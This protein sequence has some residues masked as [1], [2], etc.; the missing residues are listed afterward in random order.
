MTNSKMMTLTSHSGERLTT[1]YRC[2]TTKT[3]KR[4]TLVSPM[5]KYVWSNNPKLTKERRSTLTNKLITKRR[6]RSKKLMK[7]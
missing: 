7:K 3:K 6:N 5:G 1:S 4:K 2:K